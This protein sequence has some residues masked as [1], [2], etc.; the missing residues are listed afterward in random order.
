MMN[1]DGEDTKDEDKD[2][3]L[4]PISNLEKWVRHVTLVFRPHHPILRNNNIH[5]YHPF[6]L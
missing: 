2:L 5:E 6:H 4:K 1:E 3:E